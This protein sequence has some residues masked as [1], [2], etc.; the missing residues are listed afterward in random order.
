MAYFPALNDLGLEG[1]QSV[2]TDRHRAEGHGDEAELWLEEVAIEIAKSGEA[3]IRFLLSC[4]PGAD[5]R[6]LR[7]ILAGLGSIRNKLSAR[8]RIEICN[9]G[10]AFL[11]DS[12]PM[13]IAEAVDLL[14]HHGCK[15]ARAA[16]L[17]HR[18]HRSPYVVGS[19][20]RY[21]SRLFPRM[22]VPM[23]V[24]ALASGEPV[25]RQNG[26]DELDELDCVEALPTIKSLLKD[27]DRFVRQAARTAVKNLEKP[28]RGSERS[29]KSL[30]RR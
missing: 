22:A 1:L 24:Q 7:A 2:F 6:R 8:R 14:R 23:L 18:G 3:G 26:I 29:T 27:K 15:S 30:S 25:V 11:N 28:T 5:S 20:L 19:V 13:I 4:I 17:K 10:R 21:M 12:R 16:I 9:V